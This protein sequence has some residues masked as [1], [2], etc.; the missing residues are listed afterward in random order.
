MN[1]MNGGL[2][3][4][5]ELLGTLTSSERKVAEFILN[6]PQRIID[7]SVAQL[8]EESG[9]SQAAVVRMC[10]SAGF[11]GYQE[12]KLKVAGDLQNQHSYS[13]GYMEIKVDSTME[14]LIDT[15]FNNN[16]Q[17]ILDT[18]KILSAVNMEKAVNLLLKAN[19]IIFYGVGASNLVA[20][21][22][23]QK[24]TRINKLCLAF[25][26]TD[27]Q[28]IS[29]VMVGQDDVVVGISNSGESP[30]VVECLRQARER[31]A[32]IIS[33]T[34]YGQN[35][36]SKLADIPLFISSTE[37]E[38][39]SGATSS[40]ITQL[41]LIDILYLAVSS[42]NYNQSVKYLDLTRKIVRKPLNGKY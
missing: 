3:R 18:R 17:S 10:K 7:M 26:D 11:K 32:G 31:G 15:V 30:T 41:H 5:R 27:Q 4:L 1:A 23:Q 6:E 40:R 24:F 22:A 37:T 14:Q 29:S 12:L 35:T 13:N 36:V 33:I 2:V 25:L 16:I 39:R 19:K 9:G 8:A 21:D 38:I 20:I 28:L 34:R 42:R